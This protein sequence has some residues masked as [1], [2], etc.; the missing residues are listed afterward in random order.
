MA[1]EDESKKGPE[2]KASFSS[3]FIIAVA[4]GFDKH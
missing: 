4:L 3:R 2:K 1:D